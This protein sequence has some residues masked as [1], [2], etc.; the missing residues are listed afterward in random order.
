MNLHGLLHH[1]VLLERLDDDPELQ[2]SPEQSICLAGIHR[3]HHFLI[4]VH[5]VRAPIPVCEEWED[6]GGH[7]ADLKTNHSGMLHGE[8]DHEC[9][10][11]LPS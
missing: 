3:Q 6:A 10:P 9:I 1:L 8:A 5:P 7:G 2:N 11:I 4:I